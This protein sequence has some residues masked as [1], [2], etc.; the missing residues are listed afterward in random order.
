LSDYNWL[1]KKLTRKYAEIL[2]ELGGDKGEPNGDQLKRQLAA[3]ET[4]IQIW[5]PDWSGGSIQPIKTRKRYTQRGQQSALIHEFVRVNDGVLSA[6]SAA[7]YVLS[8]L[9]LNN[10]STP[11]ERNIQ[12]HAHSIFR[13][14][15]KTL[16]LKRMNT[17]P[18]NWI[19]AD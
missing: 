14:L 1:I 3:L 7:K 12:N 13:K 18:E 5:E 9:E 4:V 19:R 6:S 15:E 17:R 8:R 2:G 10:V 11:P 16:F